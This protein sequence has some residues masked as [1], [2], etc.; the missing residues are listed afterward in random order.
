MIKK[1]KIA[2]IIFAKILKLPL[3]GYLTFIERTTMA[4]AGSTST[5]EYTDEGSLYARILVKNGDPCFEIPDKRL[6]NIHSVGILMDNKIVCS[7]NWINTRNQFSMHILKNLLC[8]QKKFW[9]SG[10]KMDL[11]PLTLKGFLELYPMQYLD[12][13]RLSRLISNLSVLSPQKNPVC[14]KDLFI[15]R[16]RYFAYQIKRIIERNKAVLKD[17]DIQYLLAAERINL[18]VR[19]ICNSRR[20][21]NIPGHKGRN[22]DYYGRGI[23]FSGYIN[24]VKKNP[25]KFRLNPVF[26]N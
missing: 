7:L 9:L 3:K 10:K 21:L 26:T 18:S 16:R 17:K 6:E 22:P 4:P 15:S 20:L 2:K 13:S 5:G 23:T 12:Q 11:K 1:Q 24:L 14:L 25:V 19:T 8:Y